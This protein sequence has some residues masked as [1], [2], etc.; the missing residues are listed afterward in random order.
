[1]RFF[2]CIADPVWRSRLLCSI[3]EN[4]AIRRGSLL[5]WGCTLSAIILLFYAETLL[6]P[7]YL[8]ASTFLFTVS[9][10]DLFG[11]SLDTIALDVRFSSLCARFGLLSLVPALYAL[12]TSGEK[13]GFAAEFLYMSLRNT[14]GASIY[15]I[16]TCN[17]LEGRVLTRIGVVI[18]HS[19]LLQSIVMY[20]GVIVSSGAGLTRS[21]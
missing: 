4:G 20:A 10:T 1:M 8:V 13:V 14:L 15:T 17:T 21:L 12:I 9:I 3:R 2:T 16:C 5:I 6:R 19:I 7:L 11:W 18:M